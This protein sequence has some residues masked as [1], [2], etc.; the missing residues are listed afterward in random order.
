[1]TKL[2]SIVLLC[3]AFAQPASATLLLGVT[4]SNELVVFDSATPQT[5][6]LVA[7]VGGLPALTTITDIDFRPATGELYGLAYTNIADGTTPDLI[8]LYRI[9]PSTGAATAVGSAFTLSFDDGQVGNK[10]TNNGNF[11]FTFDYATPARVH[12]L[13]NG[14]GLTPSRAIALDPD[15][16][17]QVGATLSL[18]GADFYPA[19]GE[20]FDLWGFQADT[21]YGWAFS[22]NSLCVFNDATGACSA[23]GAS[24]ISLDVG[25]ASVQKIGLDIDPLNGIFLVGQQGNQMRLYAV[26]HF[27]GNASLLGT[28]SIATIRDVAV[29]PP[30]VPFPIFNDGFE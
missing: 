22:T 13:L 12:V 25:L 10:I 7:L 29:P 21:F 5:T 17:A 8:Q 16:G 24:G 11:G 9:D 27:T 15:T 18:G 14:T 2:A 26:D 28:F 20:F 23:V 1:M 4:S 6:S 19:L 30:T 3:V